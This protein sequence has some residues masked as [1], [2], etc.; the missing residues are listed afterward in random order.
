MYGTPFQLFESGRKEVIFWQT[1]FQH[2]HQ[3]QL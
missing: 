1:E 3:G 2:T